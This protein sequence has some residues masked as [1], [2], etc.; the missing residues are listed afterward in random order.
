MLIKKSRWFIIVFL[1]SFLS[2]CD[3]NL[4]NSL[5]YAGENRN[6]LEKVLEHFKDDPN[7]L[8]YEAAKFLIKNMPYHNRCYGERAK[9]YD[10]AYVAMAKEPIEFRDSVFQCKISGI[11]SNNI[12]KK[13]DIMTMKSDF[14]IKFIDEVCETW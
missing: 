10:D 11:G 2:S 3:S 5:E 13:S 4:E 14:L 8:K 12:E 1:L 7:P 9:V 6:E